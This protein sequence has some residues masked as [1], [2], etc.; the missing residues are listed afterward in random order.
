MNDIGFIVQQSNNV[1]IRIF[2]FFLQ[3]L[4]LTHDVALL[5]TI[6][7]FITNTRIIFF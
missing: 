7:S 2:L 3:L 4:R 1:I 6:N 5:Y